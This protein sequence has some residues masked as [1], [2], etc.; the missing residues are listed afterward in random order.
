MQFVAPNMCLNTLN[1][2]GSKL[3]NLPYNNII[4]CTESYYQNV[5]FNEIN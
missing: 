2:V 1:N 5:K 4:I 3:K